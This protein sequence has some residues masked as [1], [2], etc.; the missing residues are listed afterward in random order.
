MAERSRALRMLETAGIAA[1]AA[2]G[3]AGAA[4]AAERAIVARTRRRPDPDAGRPLKP[5]YDEAHAL[6][7]HDGGTLATISRGH[8]PT[9]L[10]S[11]GH[12]LSVNT[13]VHQFDA[14]PEQGF[15]VVAFDHRGHG[16][17]AA[18]SGGYSIESLA[19]DV[20][21]VLE[22]LDLHDVV[23]VGHSMGGVAVIEFAVRFPEIVAQRVRGLVLLSTLVKTKLRKTPRLRSVVAGLADHTPALA[24]LMARPDFGFLLARIGF[25]RN[26]TASHV[27]LT[28]RMIAACAPATSHGATKALIGMDLT[29]GLPGIR[30]P[31]VVVA[32]TADVITLPFEARRIVHLIPGARLEMLEGGGHML[33]LEQ[34]AE[35]NRLIAEFTTEVT[36]APAPNVPD[37]TGR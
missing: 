23:M 34:A 21:T 26:P 5:R 28:R 25:G 16:D 15:R 11:H 27:E 22:G 33:M 32:G 3:L 36:A 20:R 9:I 4:W 31:T 30:V 14:L 18:G 7:S 6:A 35:L 37:T 29:P 24:T 10:L 2:A 13:W 8:G 1:G 19:L 12:S 17:S